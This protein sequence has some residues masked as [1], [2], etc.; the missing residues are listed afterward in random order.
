MRPRLR[1]AVVAVAAGAAL[2]PLR[3]A[4]R[5]NEGADGR[6]ESRRSAHFLLLQDVDLDQRTGPRG[7]SR[8]EHDVL[9]VLEAAY[10]QLDD[11][12]GLRP[13]RRLEVQIHDAARFDEAFAGRFPFRIAGFYGGVI[14]IRGDLRVTPALAATLRHELVHAALDAEAP[15][16][17]L[18]A[19]LEEGTA[20][21]FESRA[22]GRPALDPR[23]RAWL[24]EAGARG[25]LLGIDALSGPSF[26]GLPGDSAA[27]AYLQSRALVDQLVQLGGERELRAFLARVLRTGNLDRAL[28]ASSGV[29]APGLEAALL[30]DLGVGR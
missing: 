20:E 29:D 7:T 16:L 10:D 6:F 27:L 8:F 21:W 2:L 23:E 22:A 25:E 5:G 30:A 24:A 15:G 17:V 11:L 4:S 26:A 18:P 19:W 3:A 12:L 14:R 13:R 1:L 28:A 9:D